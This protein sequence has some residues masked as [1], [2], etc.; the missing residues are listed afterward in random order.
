MFSWFSTCLSLK[1][2]LASWN[3]P[4]QIVWLFEDVKCLIVFQVLDRLFEF[5]FAEGII[6]PW[7][8]LIISALDAG[9]SCRSGLLGTQLFIEVAEGFPFC[10]PKIRTW[11]MR[12]WTLPTTKWW[13]FNEDLWFQVSSSSMKGRKGNRN[14][15]GG[16]TKTFLFFPRKLDEIIQIW[17]AYVSNGLVQAP[18]RNPVNIIL[19]FSDD[20]CWVNSLMHNWFGTRYSQIVQCS[21]GSSWPPIWEMPGSSNNFDASNMDPEKLGIFHGSLVSRMFFHRQ[22]QQEVFWTSFF[23][24]KLFLLEI[25]PKI[26]G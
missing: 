21:G 11:N 12:Q 14:L 23:D 3:V 6:F 5:V 26:D 8:F 24:Y 4:I 2:V 7:N 9:L 19:T 17:R 15:D 10:S 1:R 13:T 16:W 18:A 25:N 20:I 22:W